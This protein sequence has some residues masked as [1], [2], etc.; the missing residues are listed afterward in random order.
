LI[1]PVLDLLERAVAKAWA[2]HMFQ[3]DISRVYKNLDAFDGVRRPVKEAAEDALRPFLPT[4]LYAGW[5]D[6]SPSPD[7]VEPWPTFVDYGCTVFNLENLTFIH[8]LYKVI[9]P[10]LLHSL[11]VEHN[12]YVNGKAVPRLLVLDN[13]WRLNVPT[14]TLTRI[15]REGLKPNTAVLSI[16]DSFIDLRHMTAGNVILANCPHRAYFTSP[17]MNFNDTEFINAGIPEEALA[18]VNSHEGQDR[19]YFYVSLM[20]RVVMLD[21]KVSESPQPDLA[22]QDVTPASPTFPVAVESALP[23]GLTTLTEN[24]ISTGGST[25][26]KG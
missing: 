14:A 26:L 11:T 24:S 13:L 6:G 21:L 12:R 1:T 22:S 8:Q 2:E 25:P 23:E 3:A 7:Q 10:A 4:E 5:L 20:D 15:F 9:V 19:H 16:S 18:Q 17:A